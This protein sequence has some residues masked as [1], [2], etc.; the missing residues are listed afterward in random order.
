VFTHSYEFIK[1]KDYSQHDPQI[2]FTEGLVVVV[3][4]VVVVVLV[5]VVVVVEDDV[6]NVDS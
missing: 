2:C 3:V 6:V 4:V 5:E 1:N